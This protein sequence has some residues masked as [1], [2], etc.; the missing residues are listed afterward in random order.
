VTLYCTRTQ[1]NALVIVSTLTSFPAVAGLHLA[2][3]RLGTSLN[4]AG[5]KPSQPQPRHLFHTTVQ[6]VVINCLQTLPSQLTNTVCHVTSHHRNSNRGAEEKALESE[7][8]G[9]E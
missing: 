9:L 4:C 6:F 8:E 2:T 7:A 1:T 5:M 3:Y